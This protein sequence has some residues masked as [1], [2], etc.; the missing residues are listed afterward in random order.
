M[1]AGGR[2]RLGIDAEDLNGQLGSYFGAPDGEGVL[3]REV[4]GGSAAEKAGLKSGDV[5][6]SLDGERIRSLGDLREQL[7]SKRDAKTVK[8]GV[9]RNKSEMTIGVEMPPL[10][11]R[12]NRMISRR[13]N[14]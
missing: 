7:A 10:P 1:I 6:T 14:I 3:I 4:N 13:T 8:L 5:I 12:T 9:L 2:P 11:S